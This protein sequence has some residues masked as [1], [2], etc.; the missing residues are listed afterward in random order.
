M[1]YYIS[2]DQNGQAIQS[3]YCQDDLVQEQCSV[4]AVTL[5]TESHINVADVYFDGEIKYKPQKP[6]SY[7]TWDAVLKTWTDAR[8]QESEWKLVRQNRDR[9]LL[10]SDWTQLPDVPLATQEAW[11]GYRQ[12][13]R[14]I[15]LQEDP[16]NIV[17]P[18]VP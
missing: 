14:D 1:K 7:F 4:A 13:L 3:G 11:R 9:L 17:W 12:E 18:V 2:F 6:E 10:E 16:F 5:E 15:T 8:T